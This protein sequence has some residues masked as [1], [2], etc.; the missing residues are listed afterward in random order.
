[1]ERIELLNNT[2]LKAIEHNHLDIANAML[3]LGANIQENSPKALNAA[4]KECNI[5]FV[6]LF[7]EYDFYSNGTI[8]SNL[9]KANHNQLTELFDI[10]KEK[11]PL[12]AL[13]TELLTQNIIPNREKLHFIL[14]LENR[15]DLLHKIEAEIPLHE[16]YTLNNTCAVMLALNSY[17]TEDQNTVRNEAID[18]VLDR[19]VKNKQAF[20]EDLNRNHFCKLL[21][22]LGYYS[23]GVELSEGINVDICKVRDFQRMYAISKEHSNIKIKLDRNFKLKDK[24]TT[25]EEFSFILDSLKTEGLSFEFARSELLP[26]KREHILFFTNYLL[27]YDYR[28]VGINKVFHVDSKERD[29]VEHYK[30]LAIHAPEFF[31]DALIALE[32]NYY[33]VNY[34]SEYLSSNEYSDDIAMAIEDYTRIRI[35]ARIMECNAISQH[36][37]TECE[38]HNHDTTPYISAFFYYRDGESLTLIKNPQ[39][40]K[41]VFTMYDEKKAIQFFKG[42]IKSKLLP[43]LTAERTITKQDQSNDNM[44]QSEAHRYYLAKFSLILMTIEEVSAFINKTRKPEKIASLIRYTRFT[45]LEIMN[46]GELS[47]E[48]KAYALRSIPHE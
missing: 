8:Y 48:R 16:I 9:Y 38:K 20:V 2:L 17:A 24:N 42:Y 28:S 1:M 21:F 35:Y 36:M 23:E 39:F 19:L 27:N 15:V 13:K 25:I 29:I 22:E 33:W 12:S 5:D 37:I 14:L 47:T 34:L 7:F 44:S 41:H 18:L 31:V 40:I 30:Y 45:P 32:S 26:L 6:K 46:Y 3:S 43:P 10:I 4:V 11:V